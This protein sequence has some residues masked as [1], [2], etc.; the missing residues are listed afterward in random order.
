MLAPIPNVTVPLPVPLAPLSTW[1]QPILLVAVQAQVGPAVTAMVVPVPAAGPTDWLVGA[2]ETEHTGGAVVPAWCTVKVWPAIVSAPVRGVVTVLAATLKV[3][4]PAPLPLGPDETTIHT[5][6]VCAVHAQPAAAVTVIGAPVPP[7]AANDCS[8]GEMVYS[9]E[10]WP[11]EPDCRTV[12]CWP[13][14]P[15]VALRSVPVFAATVKVIVPLAVPVV[16]PASASQ[17]A[18]DVA[19]HVQPV[20][21]VIVRLPLPPA[22][23]IACVAGVNVKAHGAA[24]CV[25]RSRSSLTTISPSRTTAL[26]FEAA[27]NSM[28]PLP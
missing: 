8:D 13:P 12:A 2:I 3:T 27:R 19:D 22:A 16:D 18:L 14:T 1:S 10:P 20:D 7:A 11:C 4:V 6:L 9:H 26:V 24:C 17:V 28:R 5:S 23:A 21:V 25:T 15:M